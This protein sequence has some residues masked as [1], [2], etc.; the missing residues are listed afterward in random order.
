[1]NNN[2]KRI[3]IYLVMLTVAFSLVFLII[4]LKNNRPFNYG[5]LTN[6]IKPIT[7]LDEYQ[8]EIEI[9][10]YLVDKLDKEE[11]TII[12]KKLLQI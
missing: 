1:M 8:K 6:N 5:I 9:K 7:L 11:K 12:M 2:K 10:K 3:I 4:I